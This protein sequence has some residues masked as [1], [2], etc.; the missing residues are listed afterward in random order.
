MQQDTADA[1]GDMFFAKQEETAGNVVP[2][3]VP[4]AK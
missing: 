3:L 2:K 4:K 1:F